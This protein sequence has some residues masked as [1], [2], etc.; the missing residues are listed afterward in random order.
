MINT[1]PLTLLEPGLQLIVGGD[2]VIT[3]PE[4]LAR[5]FAPGDSLAYAEASGEL[6]LIPSAARRA[7]AEAVGLAVEACAKMRAVSV[8]QVNQ[9][10]AG[11]ARRLASDEIWAAIAADNRVDVEDARR[12]GRSTT[13]LVASEPLRRGMIEGLRT[14]AAVPA[15]RGRI[16]E[17]V[18]HAGWA[19]DL[20]SAELGVVAFVFEGRPNVLADATGV[21]KG[22]NCVVFRIGRDALRTALAIMHTALVPALH[23]AGL[24]ENAVR[25]VDSAE[26]AAGWALFT[27]RRVSLAVARGSGRA[28]AVLGSLARQSGVPVSLHG[29]GGAWLV[30]SEATAAPDLERVVTASL[31][32]KVCNTLNVCCL[33]RAHAQRLIPAFLKGLAEAGARRAQSFKLHLARQEDTEWTRDLFSRTIGVARAE[34]VVQEAQAEHIDESELGREWEWEE[35]PEVTLKL[36]DDVDH[37]IR[38]FN[39]YS[40]Q[41]IACLLSPDPA[42]QQRFFELVNA[43]FVGDDHTRWVDGQVALGRPE[44]GLSNWEYGRLLA[45]GGVLSGD[46]IYTIRSRARRS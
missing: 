43:P 8:E 38:L 6:L 24:P 13:R 17:T 25:L 30:A 33:P 29:T 12:R 19:V 2:R 18:Q 36:V 20:V 16:I 41:F 1:R 26:H 32:R 4:E 28:V 15:S 9:F 21:L 27:D 42:E 40:P 34:G 37:A 5:R 22:G 45:R 44:L 46:S 11:F 3:V 31:D 10:Y 7:A 14:W 23:E 35:T 39:A